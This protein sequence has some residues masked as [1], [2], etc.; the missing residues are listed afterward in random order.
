MANLILTPSGGGAALRDIAGADLTLSPAAQRSRARTIHPGMVAPD[1]DPA[2]HYAFSIV[3]GITIASLY[4][5]SAERDGKRNTWRVQWSGSDPNGATRAALADLTAIRN[6]IAVLVAAHPAYD[7]LDI[8][9]GS[10]PTYIEDDLGDVDH[11][12]TAD[13]EQVGL[14]YQIA[15]SLP[16]GG[17]LS[18]VPLISGQATPRVIPDATGWAVREPMTPSPETRIISC[19]YAQPMV[20]TVTANP[21]GGATGLEVEKP[22]RNIQAARAN[23]AADVP[24][25]PALAHGYAIDAV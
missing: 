8:V 5:V 6:A 16:P 13:R 15:L 18:A 2:T 7:A 1:V 10:L 22:A 24:P 9:A 19:Q 25:T 3:G 17:A 4:P 21:S 23:P 20:G 14:E 12:R 11:R